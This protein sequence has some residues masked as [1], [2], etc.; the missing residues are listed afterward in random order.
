MHNYLPL[1]IGF[2]YTKTKCRNG[3]VSLTS[4]LS[5][6]GITLGLM[7]LITVMSVMNGFNYEIRNYL[8]N[9]TNHITISSQ[10]GDLTHDDSVFDQLSR[11]KTIQSASPFFSSQALLTHQGFSQGIYL[12]GILP[13]YLHKTYH[14]NISDQS[15]IQP[16]QFH[17]VLSQGLADQLNVTVG[18]RVTVIV[19]QANVTV[20]GVMPRYKQFRISAIFQPTDHS[21]MSEQLAFTHLEDA[22][23]LFRVGD[24]LT[25]IH[26]GVANLYDSPHVTATLRTQLGSNYRVSDWSDHFSVLFKSLQLQKTMMAFILFFII[27]VAA[28]NLVSSL[29]MMVMDKRSDIAIL[30]THGMTTFSIMSI[31]ISQGL[32]IGLVSTTVGTMLG[33]MLSHYITGIS[34]LL[35]QI[36]QTHFI[37][38]DA[39]F[40]DFLPSRI[41][42]S[43]IVWVNGSSLLLCLLAA[44]YPAWKAANIQPAVELKYQ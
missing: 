7:V 1:F 16:G 5:M 13:Q 31:F 28:F 20:M 14:V 6:A 23:R 29:V 11:N 35:E 22:Q 41:R 8:F 12:S 2:R 36:L 24:E 37:S 15:T 33:V 27:L 40:I 43:D 4:L 39:Y 18:D 30:R 3:F 44:I 21:P 38:P 26:L 32:I 10:Y 25:G 34:G 19:P 42:Y 17:L 9:I